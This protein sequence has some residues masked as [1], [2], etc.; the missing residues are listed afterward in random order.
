MMELEPKKVSE[1][2]TEMNEMVMPNDT[3][4]L[5]NLMGGNLMRW[6]DIA[7]S[8][9]ASRHCESFVVTVSVDHLTFQEPI[10]LGD[11]VTIRAQVT[12]SFHTSIEIFMEVFTKGILQHSPR[13]S[14]QAYFTFVALDE[15]TMKPKNVTG[16]I[17][18]TNEE[19]EQFEG[20]AIRREF[21]LV[22]SGKIKPSE[23]KQSQ[24]FLNS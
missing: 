6:M 3:N 23:A 4:P 8:I 13:K 10:K 20:A 12:R 1:S 9:C 21:R 17:A 19:K 7:S 14:N 2:I 24:D 18:E 5:G 11:I 22:V 16:V 15:R